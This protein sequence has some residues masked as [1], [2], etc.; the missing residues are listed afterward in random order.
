MSKR[1]QGIAF[2]KMENGNI[3]AYNKCSDDKRGISEFQFTDPTNIS[4]TVLCSI[5]PKI[6]LYDE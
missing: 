6:I 2:K 1:S 3:R 5:P 4:P